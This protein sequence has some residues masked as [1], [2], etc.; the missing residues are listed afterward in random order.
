M[1]TT[2]QEPTRGI[3]LVESP[4][5]KYRLPVNA[6]II[7]RLSRLE[8]QS[9]DDLTKKAGA[10][11]QLH[12]NA[13]FGWY[14]ASTFA[15]K[16]APFPMTMTGRDSWVFTAYVMLLD[17]GIHRNRDVEDALQICQD[18]GA[19]AKL[20]ALLLTGL[21]Q[22]IDAHLSLVAERT[23]YPKC[24][25]EAFEI[26]FFNVFDRHQDG[27]YLSDIV[28]PETRVV[29][30]A[31]APFETTPVE[32]LLL[33]VAY[34]RRD[35]DL[36]LHLAGMTD[37][38][39]RKELRSLP[40]SALELTSQI[41][42]N[43]LLMTKMSLMNQPSAGMEKA[44]ALLA[45]S[46]KQQSKT[47]DSEPQKPYDTAGEL[48]AYLASV[49]PITEADRQDLQAAARPGKS[50][51][52]DEDGNVMPL[53]SDESSPGTKPPAGTQSYTIVEFPEPIS[54]VWRSQDCDKPVVIVA[55]MSEPG[56]P[57]FYKTEDGSGIPAS[58]VFFDIQASP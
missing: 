6:K 52:H 11:V 55:R 34:N 28:Y 20:K 57:V 9:T 45:A 31:D 3:L 10:F 18:P 26:L 32:D 19:S 27:L 5:L 46:Q 40:E 15:R 44:T 14:I 29:E 39:C 49:P 58:E 36:V 4:W 51:W 21:G 22:P 38:D 33:R 41:M 56:L 54:A 25:V 30:F 50:Y 37:A 43:A 48:K 1:A 24:T 17:P 16:R 12:T 42:G 2:D 47:G 8:H 23:G 35:I 53:D 7:E 13:A